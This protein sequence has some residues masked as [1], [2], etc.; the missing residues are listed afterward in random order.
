MRF[1]LGL[2]LVAV[3]LLI[4]AFATGILSAEQTQTAQLPSIK[5]EGGQL[6]GFQVKRADVK[7][8]TTN[9]TVEV[10]AVKVDKPK[11]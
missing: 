7:I 2:A 9:T 10:P 6:P 3:L 11:Q 4:A 5:A 1:L 8:G